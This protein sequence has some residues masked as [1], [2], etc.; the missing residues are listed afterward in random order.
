MTVSTSTCTDDWAADG[1]AR[2]SVTPAPATCFLTSLAKS[3]AFRMVGGCSGNSSRRWSASSPSPSK[4]SMACASE[5]TQRAAPPLASAMAQSVSFRV[6]TGT[7]SST[8]PSSCSRMATSHAFEVLA[9][10]CPSVSAKMRSAQSSAS[11]AE[12]VLANAR[13][14]LLAWS[15]ASYSFVACWFDLMRP[16]RV[17][18]ESKSRVGWSSTVISLPN[19]TRPMAWG[20][21]NPTILSTNVRN[22]I[23][24][25]SSRDLSLSSDDL[26]RILDETSSTMQ[27][28]CDS[29]LLSLSSPPV[30]TVPVIPA[31]PA[32]PPPAV[33]V[34]VS[35]GGD[36]ALPRSPAPLMASRSRLRTAMGSPNCCQSSAFIWRRSLR[37]HN[38]SS[39]R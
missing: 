24:L 1:A 21:S 4:S 27:S 39:S 7:A 11:S 13:S 14:S 18:N 9:L 36:A 25:V 2:T 38:S 17:S 15:T 5:F 20:S 29:S 33:S 8:T 16:S 22:R 34:P 12:C 10:S 23:L 31:V 3:S 35:R 28:S 30:P 6:P 32:E 26:A 19:V 37:V